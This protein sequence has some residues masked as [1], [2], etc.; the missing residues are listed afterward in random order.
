MVLQAQTAAA[1]PSPGAEQ[2][3]EALQQLLTDVQQQ[4]QQAQDE[5]ESLSERAQVS[6]MDRRGAAGCTGRTPES[7]P[8]RMSRSS[9]RCA[10]RGLACLLHVGSVALHDC[11]EPL[12]IQ[13]RYG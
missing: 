2:E 10:R 3:V 13:A 11:T 8:G 6:D 4:L 5:R 7:R 9:P 1:D 12:C